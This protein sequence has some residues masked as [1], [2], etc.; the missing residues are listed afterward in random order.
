M[1]IFVSTIIHHIPKSIPKFVSN[2]ISSMIRFVIY[3][4]YFV[5]RFVDFVVVV[6]VVVVIV[7]MKRRRVSERP[8]LPDSTVHGMGIMFVNKFHVCHIF[9]AI[10]HS[11]MSYSVVPRIGPT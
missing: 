2:A 4:V 5:N 11:W 8:L 10:H 6:V 9:V 1:L 7:M 3:H